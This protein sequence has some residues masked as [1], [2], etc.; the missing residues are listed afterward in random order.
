MDQ[1]YGALILFGVAWP[2][3]IL[4]NKEQEK[5]PWG[6]DNRKVLKYIE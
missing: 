5:E 3:V 2:L 6:G 4:H 1:R